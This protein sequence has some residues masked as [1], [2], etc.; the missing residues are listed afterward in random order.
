LKMRATEARKER[1]RAMR[2]G[3]KDMLRRRRRCKSARYHA[4]LTDARR[5]S[6]I[7]E[8]LKSP[9]E[10]NCQRMAAYSTSSRPAR[11]MAEPRAEGAVIRRFCRVASTYMS[12]AFRRKANCLPPLCHARFPRTAKSCS[13]PTQPEREAKS[14]NRITP[15]AAGAPEGNKREV[16]NGVCIKCRAKRPYSPQR[17]R[18]SRKAV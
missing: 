18:R 4:G 3:E 15:A 5:M 14:R 10:K 7:H 13:P 16:R 12:P 2:R 6:G 11:H 9:E 17:R 8:I 1:Q